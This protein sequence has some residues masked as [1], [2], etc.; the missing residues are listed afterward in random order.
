MGSS[1][2]MGKKFWDGHRSKKD[3]IFCVQNI[4]VPLGIGHSPIYTS[5]QVYMFAG[6]LKGHITASK[7]TFQIFC[8]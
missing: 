4:K 1:A 5:I 6:G 7:G 3:V 2:K 8:G